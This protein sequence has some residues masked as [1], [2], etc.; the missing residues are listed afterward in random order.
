MKSLKKIF[1]HLLIIIPAK[2]N[3]SRLKNKNIYSVGKKKLIE[4]T[5]DQIKTIGL[6][7]ILMFQ[8]ILIKLLV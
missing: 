1:D 7:K 8:L 2:G 5:F 6:K 3:S 4:Y